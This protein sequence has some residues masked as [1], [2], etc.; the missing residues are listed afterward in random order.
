[1]GLEG[2]SFSRGSG[3]W[4]YGGS[5]DDGVAGVY[6]YGDFVFVAVGG[7][8]VVNLGFFLLGVPMYAVSCV[9]D[10]ES[11]PYCCYPCLMESTIFT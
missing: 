3:E 10:I 2:I 11:A 4:C 8:K 1:M 9:S 5:R 6:F 7:L